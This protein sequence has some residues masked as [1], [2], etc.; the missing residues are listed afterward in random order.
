MTCLLMPS[1]WQRQSYLVRRWGEHVVSNSQQ[2][3]AIRCFMCIGV[4][5]TEPWTSPTAPKFG[6]RVISP[7]PQPPSGSSAESKDASNRMTVK[8]SALKLITSFG[9]HT[10]P[11]FRF[12]GLKS[13]DRTPT[14]APGVT[15]IAESAVGESALSPGGLGSYRFNNIRSINNA[16]SARTTTPVGF[17]RGRLPSIG[18]TPVDVHPPTFPAPKSLPTPVDSSSEK[19]K[20]EKSSTDNDG[21][22]GEQPTLALLTSARYTPQKDSSHGP[23]PQTAVQ[24]GPSQFEGIK[25][26]PSPPVAVF[27]SLKD[28]A[29][30][31]NGSRDRKPEGL[32]IQWPPPEAS[33]PDTGAFSGYTPSNEQTDTTD[34]RSPASTL[35]SLK[36][37]KSTVSGRSID[38]Y[39]NSLDEANYYAKHNRHHHPRTRDR[40][41]T[42][43]STTDHKHSSRNGSIDSRG[44]SNSRYIPPAKRSPSSPVPMSPEEFAKYNASSE[45]LGAS[46]ETKKHR[47]RSH[48]KGSSRV[49][50]SST[51]DPRQRS[52]SKGIDRKLKSS[53]RNRSGRRSRGRSR[54][55]GISAVASPT[56]PLPMSPS[57]PELELF[58]G[59]LRLVTSDREQRL[60]SRQ[61]SPSR[62]PERGSSARRD[63]SP[64]RRRQRARS[65]SRQARNNTP[66][67]EPTPV[68][69]PAPAVEG[70]EES[71]SPAPTSEVL[72]IAER[73]KRETAAAELEA[74]RL[75]LAR[76]PSA[77]NIPLPG[78][79]PASAAPA[80][81]TGS[82]DSPPS[83]GG[84]FSQRARTR[85]NASRPSPEFPNGSDSGSS[86]GRPTA[87]VGL[88]VTPR[89]MRHPKYSDG[90]VDDDAPAVPDLPQTLP[91]AT[92]QADAARISRSMSVPIVEYQPAVPLNLPY[93]PRYNPVIPRSRSTSRTRG[94]MGHRRE[95]SRDLPSVNYGSSPPLSVSIETGSVPDT[96]GAPPIL[97][98]LQ[99]LTTP[100]P[101]PPA[102]VAEGSFSSQTVKAAIDNAQIG[103]NL[104][105][106]FTTG[107]SAGEIQPVREGRR[108]SI[109]HRRGRSI[110]ES[111]AT[112]IRNF[113]GRMRST[114]RGPS[115]RSPPAESPE[116]LSPYESIQM[117]TAENRF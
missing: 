112:K 24:T 79:P 29:H 71:Q 113:T 60:R 95:G 38:R 21:N 14:N 104:P 58:E 4:E 86:R 1:D 54:D 93:H 77:P 56:S 94:A 5:P 74:R 82:V 75:S 110:N 33:E 99:H 92:Y 40:R 20:T 90:Y 22:K 76:R 12:P 101:P 50:T 59:S 13:D 53:S 18:E 17:S 6:L 34:T 31:R 67:P 62:R 72:T 108:M 96:K 64:D 69:T 111:I 10:N 116:K 63:P 43:A 85:S 11:A 61:R 42:E 102:P 80:A 37:G 115:T 78:G 51:A 32:H 45:S 28:Q 16:L 114:S 105:R 15:P 55:R 117:V 81:A 52:S 2:Q 65:H 7:E 57:G 25:G 3:L 98:E 35:H 19:G 89:A 49:R 36:S 70:T 66:H 44:R 39:I 68:S 88:P 87:P 103:N 107:T 48:G 23:S 30:A 46:V 41:H 97:P 83:S 9:P 27:E 109:D 100:P 47:S 26:L 91:S 8:N 106:P 84:S 73:M